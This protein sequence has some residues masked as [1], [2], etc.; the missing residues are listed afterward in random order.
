MKSL[1]GC[2]HPAVLGHGPAPQSHKVLSGNLVTEKPENGFKLVINQ[3][4]TQKPLAVSLA[5]ALGRAVRCCT[6]W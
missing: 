1:P 3:K 5:W 6:W 4:R 2:V